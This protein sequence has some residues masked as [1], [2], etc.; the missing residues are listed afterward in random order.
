MEKQRIILRI[1]N[2]EYQI[3]TDVEELQLQSLA[4]VVDEK[5]A[6]IAKQQSALT[7]SKIAVLA[8][9]ELAS[10]LDELKKAYGELLAIAKEN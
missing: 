3:R 1:F 6:N 7:P 8:A 9:L 2:E 5:M 10:E 4:R